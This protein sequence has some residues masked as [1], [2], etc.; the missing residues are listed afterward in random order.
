MQIVCHK[1][2]VCILEKLLPYNQL[3]ADLQ[4]RVNVGDP[5]LSTAWILI[6]LLGPSGKSTFCPQ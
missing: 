5:R 2:S 3:M 4:I 6:C 1:Q